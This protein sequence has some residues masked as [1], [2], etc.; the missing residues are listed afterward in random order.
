MEL[1]H[2]TSVMLHIANLL[3]SPPSAQ[4]KLAGNVVNPIVNWYRFAK[5]VFSAIAP[6]ST[7]Q[8]LMCT[9]WL[10]QIGPA[11]LVCITVRS[12][13]I[14]S[15]FTK[16]GTTASNVTLCNS[17][18]VAWTDTYESQ[19]VGWSCQAETQCNTERQHVLLQL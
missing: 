11:V 8:T 18:T 5:T 2:C 15:L 3:T 1:Q 14:Y 7:G 16:I 17:W 9:N 10:V 4:A 13:Y 12:I 19:E 6:E